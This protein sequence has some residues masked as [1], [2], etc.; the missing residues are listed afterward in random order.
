MELQNRM[1]LWRMHGLVVLLACVLVSL[2]AAM[3]F[4]IENR[5]AQQ[6][7]SR[8][9]ALD[10]AASFYEGKACGLLTQKE[11][12]ALLEE[13]VRT[14]ATV[15]PADAPT[16]A[17]RLGSPRVDTCS[18]TSLRTSAI[19]LD[20]GIKRYASAA[21][22]ERYFSESLPKVSPPTIREA[23]KLGQT[24][25]YGSNA[26]YLLRNDEVIEVS[27]ARS[28]KSNEADT[29]RFVRSILES[30]VGKL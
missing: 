14:S 6:E 12:A 10:L 7:L 13:S 11:A 21:D 8:L 28:A 23:G 5:H 22:A 3:Y 26:F 17:E 30:V 15:I 16:A 29:E 24:L 9:R 4:Y 27:A 20:L 2:C 18:Y 19:Y 25:Y 1:R